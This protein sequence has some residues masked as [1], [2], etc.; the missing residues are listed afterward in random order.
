M[1][2]LSFDMLSFMEAGLTNGSTQMTVVGEALKDLT[3]I[4]VP[5]DT[6]AFGLIMKGSVETAEPYTTNSHQEFLSSVGKLFLSIGD[7][8]AASAA[9]Y[10][11]TE[12]NNKDVAS[13]IRE[14]I[15]SLNN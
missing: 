3:T 5:P 14:R 6:T 8:L 4:L 10:T 7:E 1:S 11:A 9:D 12:T 2:A 15:D 13:K